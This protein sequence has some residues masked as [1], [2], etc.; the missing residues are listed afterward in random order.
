MLIPHGELLPHESIL[1]IVQFKRASMGYA[2][3]YMQAILIRITSS[4]KANAREII[5]PLSRASPQVKFTLLP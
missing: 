3:S 2:S 5:I 1:Y 4:I